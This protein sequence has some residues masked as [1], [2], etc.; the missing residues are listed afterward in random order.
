[1]RSVTNAQYHALLASLAIVQIR[2]FTWKTK[3]GKIRSVKGRM[4]V[5]WFSC[6]SFRESSPATFHDYGESGGVE[7]P[8]RKQLI[9]HPSRKVKSSFFSF[10]SFLSFFLLLPDAVLS[11]LSLMS[12]TPSFHP[13]CYFN[14]RNNDWTLR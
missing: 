2:K 13:R 8:F 10:F 12:F 11:R 6:Y 7:E 5:G 3:A 14:G 9:P 4:V 1:M